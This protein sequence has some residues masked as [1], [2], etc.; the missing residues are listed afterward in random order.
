MRAT[1]SEHI[2]FHDRVQR[3]NFNLFTVRH[4][5]R[6]SLHIHWSTDVNIKCILNETPKERKNEQKVSLSRV[7]VSI[8]MC[9]FSASFW[10]RLFVMKFVALSVKSPTRQN[11]LPNVAR[12]AS[13]KKCENEYSP[14][15]SLRTH[16]Q[17]AH[18]HEI[19]RHSLSSWRV[20]RSWANHLIAMRVIYS[21]PIYRNTSYTPIVF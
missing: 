10:A 20:T 17:T 9:R 13:Q 7:C 4:S 3:K 5:R 18:R 12:F 11:T 8:Q 16:Q 14:L 2:S 1:K 21:D 19:P 15:T 6:C